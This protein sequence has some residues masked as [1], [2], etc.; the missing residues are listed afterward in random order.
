[1]LIVEEPDHDAASWRNSKFLY[2]NVVPQ[3]RRGMDMNVHDLPV[4]LA[5]SARQMC[6]TPSESSRISLSVPAEEGYRRLI[7]IHAAG[8]RASSH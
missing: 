2:A 1:M 5:T 4:K 3:Y 8:L 6:C 7:A